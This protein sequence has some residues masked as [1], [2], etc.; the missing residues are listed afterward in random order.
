MPTETLHR[1]VQIRAF[2]AIIVASVLAA[3]G[4]GGGGTGSGGSG[5][6]VVAENCRKEATVVRSGSFYGG[7]EG[8]DGGG[9]GG[10]GGGDGAGDGSGGQGQ[11]LDTRVVVRNRLMEVIGEALTDAENGMVAIDLKGCKD[12]VQI[13]FVGGPTA[14]YYDESTR[15]YEPFR[16]GEVLRARL[17]QLTKN[18][19][20]SP[21]T[22]AAVRMM[23]A[24]NGGTTSTLNVEQI[25]RINAHVGRIVAD[26]VPGIFRPRNP[27]GSF[28]PLDITQLAAVLNP[29]KATRAG[30]LTDTPYGQMGAI[31]A[32]LGATA[33]AYSEKVDR[34]A[35]RMT[36]LFASDLADGK[37]D[38]QG[39][40]GPLV[41]ES[42]P[43]L[44][45]PDTL[46]RSKSVAAGTASASIGDNA[47]QQK[48]KAAAVA[49]Y[50]ATLQSVYEVERADE[51][52]FVT[53]S[54]G[55]QTVRLYADGALTIK[56]T[57]SSGFTAA[58]WYE[59]N[60]NPAEIPIVAG[61]VSGEPA[62]FSDVKVGSRGEAIALRSD[63]AGFVYVPPFE[64]YRV[65]GRETVDKASGEAILNAQAVKV[66]PITVPLPA[67]ANGL[68]VLGFTPSPDRRSYPGAIKPAFLFVLGDGSLWGVDPQRSTQAFRVASPE[69]LLS[70]VYDRFTTPFVES[71]YGQGTLTPVATAA[72]PGN[73]RLYGLTRRGKVLTWLEGLSGSGRELAIPG[74]VTMLAAESKTNV[75][76]MNS[77]GQV[78][79]INADHALAN[80]PETLVEPTTS[81][82]QYQRRYSPHQI[83]QV[84][85]GGERA[86]SMARSEAV[87]CDSGRVRIWKERTNP[88][89]FGNGS[90]RTLISNTI[91]P[92]RPV[93]SA[94]GYW[95]INAVQETFF[96][97]Q[98]E[99]TF[100]DGASYLRIDGQV[101]DSGEADGKR[102]LR[103]PV[104]D[105]PND[106]RKDSGVTGTQFRNALESVLRA[107]SPLLT[108]RTIGST[109]AYDKRRHQMTVSVAPVAV[110]RYQLNVSFDGGTSPTMPTSRF[111]IDL[112]PQSDR[113]QFRIPIFEGGDPA[114]NPAGGV[115][116]NP[117]DVYLTS[118]SVR[119][120]KGLTA[121]WVGSYLNPVRAEDNPLRAKIL[122]QGTRSDPYA[123]KVCYEMEG[124]VRVPQQLRFGAL[125]CT[126]HENDGRFRGLSAWHTHSFYVNGV[127]SPAVTNGVDFGHYMYSPY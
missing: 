127:R 113:V 52:K 24:E 87:I 15:R 12:A 35:A 31:I 11:F 53:G 100:V 124:Q 76:A 58:I 49:S 95:R 54:V 105:F 103:N 101:L 9:V 19:T 80:A 5:G 82:T 125:V 109:F 118:D 85:L 89:L 61:G 56:R 57:N 74:V 99:S 92:S 45:T 68:H 17:P 98:S 73:R 119:L 14:K 123:F 111:T 62:R 107:D 79:W 83:V 60:R 81:L 86:C 6:G 51:G 55:T 90:D 30:T 70:V 4:G 115:L 48:T 36:E 93:Q 63:R 16:D 102:D 20:V 46:W 122:P 26:Q 108:P 77:E 114:T 106:P 112:V 64:L 7:A 10:G 88:L 42:Q 50:A 96:L 32:G 39:V 66:S 34:P 47:L 59:S 18:F 3:C 44:Y 2:V 97:T 72:D 1:V 43:P 65:N 22:E 120:D 78:F 91:E 69:P 116:Q 117:A 21:F 75:Y 38:L 37:L 40:S 29:T 23:D 126:I 25:I 121:G 104:L 71:A 13:D 27:D 84:D 94:G 28:K 110:N 67:Q 41:T 8:S 33:G